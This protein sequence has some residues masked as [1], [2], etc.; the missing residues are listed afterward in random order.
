MQRLHPPA[1]CDQLG[2]EPIQQRGM[3]RRRPIETEILRRRDQ[4]LTEVPTPNVVGGDSRR[5]RIAVAGDP[6]RECQS[7]ARATRREDFTQRL[8]LRV[9]HLRRLSRRLERGS[10]SDQTRRRFWTCRRKD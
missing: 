5:T 7:S 6:V 3:R 9:R 1:V 2:S 10:R 4:R 8:V